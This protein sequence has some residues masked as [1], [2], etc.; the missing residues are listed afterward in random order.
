MLLKFKF[1][2]KDVFFKI[3]IITS[4]F[5]ALL[6]VP[7]IRKNS[8]IFAEENFLK[9][10]LKNIEWEKLEIMEIMINQI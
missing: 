7:S 3:I 10:N 6:P 8:A 9:L 4:F 5:N 2:K 1:F